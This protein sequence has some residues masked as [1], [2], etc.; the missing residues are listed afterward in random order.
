MNPSLNTLNLTTNFRYAGM[1]FE[2][3]LMLKSLASPRNKWNKPFLYIRQK[4]IIKYPVTT[5]GTVVSENGY[6]YK[7]NSIYSEWRDATIATTSR[8]EGVRKK[9]EGLDKA[10]WSAVAEPQIHTL[11]H[12][13][14]TKGWQQPKREHPNK[15][16]R[17]SYQT[18]PQGL[19]KG[20]RQKTSQS[21]R[22]Q[23]PTLLTIFHLVI[24]VRRGR[25]E[26]IDGGLKSWVVNYNDERQ[27]IANLFFIY[28]QNRTP[29]WYYYWRARKQEKG[30]LKWWRR[31]IFNVKLFSN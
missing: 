4:S 29:D 14:K 12:S 2:A 5:R 25:Y 19:M 23:Q 13:Y 6:K 3:L 20:E 18:K 27:F 17:E 1:V 10:V 30:R 21:R 7:Y 24:F 31:P 28:K 8:F 11:L 9:E 16:Q 26:V 22:V 15:Q